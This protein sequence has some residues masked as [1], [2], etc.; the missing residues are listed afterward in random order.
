M[1]A[2]PLAIRRF[3]RR[4]DGT[5]TVEWVLLT[6]LGAALAI[7]SSGLVNGGTQ[8]FASTVSEAVTGESDEDYLTVD[9]NNGSF[10]TVLGLPTASWGFDAE[11][12]EGWTEANG[13]NFEIKWDG[14]R[15]ADVHDGSWFLDMGESPG[16]LQITQ[17]FDNA[18]ADEPYRIA[19]AA[20]DIIGNNAVEVYWGG[21]FV[22]VAAPG[23]N[24][25]QTYEFD[26]TGGTGDGTNTLELRETGAVDNVG[27]YIDSVG[28]Y[29]TR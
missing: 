15:G 12:I 1:S 7:A 29:K 10:E 18:E 23:E 2:T 16:N 22:G 4:E 17:T 21:E 28:F 3:L 14:Y 8:V 20:T 19:F 9:I 26:V 24:V 11:S 5:V 27:T 25:W 6:A 13:L